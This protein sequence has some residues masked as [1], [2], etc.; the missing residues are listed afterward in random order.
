MRLR[1]G[2]KD[3]LQAQGHIHC[4]CGSSLSRTFLEVHF[5]RFKVR[6]TGKPDSLGTSKRKAIVL[7]HAENKDND[8]NASGAPDNKADVKKALTERAH[9][10]DEL[11]VS[12]IVLDGTT[13]LT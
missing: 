5:W 1:Y 8:R 11:R 7:D 3:L 13:R 4:K 9:E 12:E 2:P 6:L 10:L